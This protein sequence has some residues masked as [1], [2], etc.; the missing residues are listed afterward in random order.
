MIKKFSK[1]VTKCQISKSKNL[2]S[3]IFLGFLPPVNTLRKIGSSLEEEI[4]FP[5]EL[6]YCD[7][8]KLA[9]LGLI[10]DKKGRPVA[11][12]HGT[13]YKIKGTLSNLLVIK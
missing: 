2:R 13:P 9:Q 8:S 3:L 1:V 4:S 12:G 11:F 7:K 6:L 10:V 5:A